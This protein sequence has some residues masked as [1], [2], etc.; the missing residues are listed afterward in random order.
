MEKIKKINN[1][2]IRVETEALNKLLPLAVEMQD[3][4][5]QL[6]SD[7]IS[8]FEF[9]INERSGFVKASLS[10]E[11]F[12]FEKEY[13]RLLDL[14][15]LLKGKLTINDITASKTLKSTVLNKIKEKYTEYYTKDDLK[16]VK[17]LTDII[18]KYNSLSQQDRRNIGYNQSYELVFSP[19]S[20]LKR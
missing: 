5:N 10:A 2:M 13:K 12:G 19:F 4:L 9:K 16:L 11:A 20:Q 18:E 7:S 3:L 6:E 1:H 15:S 8:E 17:T 14:E